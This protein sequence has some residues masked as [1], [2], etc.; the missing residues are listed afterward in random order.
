MAAHSSKSERP[1]SMCLRRENSTVQS[2]LAKNIE[3]ES[4]QASFYQTTNFQEIQ[5][6]EELVMCH[7][8]NAIITT[9]TMRNSTGEQP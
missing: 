5:E 9:Q 4:G 1:D 7:Y 8:G 6:T 2:N 3:L